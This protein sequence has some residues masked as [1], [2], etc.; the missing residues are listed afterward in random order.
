MNYLPLSDIAE[1]QHL[2]D[3]PNEQAKLYKYSNATYWLNF[4]EADEIQVL[5]MIFPEKT[6]VAVVA[7][8]IGEWQ[9]TPLT[10]E[11]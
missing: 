6:E 11:K 8:Y 9:I 3:F 1:L 4:R 10:R 7:D 2:D 5:E